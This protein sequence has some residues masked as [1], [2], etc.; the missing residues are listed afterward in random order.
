MSDRR[1]SLQALDRLIRVR[2]I[3]ARQALAAAGRVEARRQAETTLVARVEGL[4]TRPVSGR[5]AGVAVSAQAASARAA[6]DAVLGALADDSRARLAATR[7]EQQRLAKALAE[8]RA[9]VDAALARRQFRKG[10]A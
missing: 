2:E 8:A 5:A 10:D 6:G 1:R 9:A 4:L 7:A 3:R